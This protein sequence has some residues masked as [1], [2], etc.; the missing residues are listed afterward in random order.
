MKPVKLAALFGDH[1][2]L[3]REMPVPVWG[4]TRPL[5]PV[6]VR[7]GPCEARGLAGEDGK[8]LVRLPPMPAGGPYVLAA[9]AEGGG[10]AESTDVMVGEVWLASGQS[11]ME[12]TMTQTGAPGQR[13]AANAADPLLRMLTV[14]REA[15]LG[16]RADL[17]ASWQC[18]APPA[19]GEFSAVGYYFARRLRAEL[20]VA[21]G[22][23]NASVGGTFIE[24]WISRERLVRNA[25]VAD[26]VAA[27]EAEVNSPAYWAAKK[28][29]RPISDFFPADPGNAAEHA[30]WARPPHDETDWKGVVLPQTWQSFGHNHSGVLWFRKTIDLPASWAG[31]DLSLRIGAVD[32]QDITY[33]NGERVGATG[34]GFK[35]E[36]WNVERDYRVPGRLVAAGKN[37]VAVRAY[38]FAYQG[39]M[40]G[41]A[42]SMCLALADQ[43]E[44]P[45][46][47]AGGWL[48]R[49]EHDLGL[50][51][52][53][54]VPPG[55]GN[56]NS[57][58]I[59][60]DSMIAPLVPAALRGALW[61]QGESNAARASEY[62]R[63]LTDL[64][65]CWRQ[66]FGL[67]DFPFLVVQL[68]NFMPEEDFQPES[69][70]ARLREAQAEVL[71]EPAT[72]L[73]V[74]IDLGEAT[75]IHPRNKQ[76][77]GARLA[78][79]ALAGIYGRPVC[80][81]G[82]LYRSMT[83][84]GDRI[85]LR[86]AH[87]GGGLAARGGPLRTFVIAGGDRGFVPAA[88]VIEGDTVVVSSP[89]VA[90]PLAVRYAWSDNPAGCNLYNAAGLPAP[91]FRTDR[92]A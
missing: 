64:I 76:D 54:A 77:V 58:Y 51:A 35:E 75:D 6:T 73:A 57:P 25:C 4:W 38:S 47:L 29:A 71:S 84:E 63:L 18:C 79:W 30:G 41:P 55:P 12:W 36:F 88:A 72:G 62:R 49:V 16:R 85:R 90:R 7:L 83:I 10:T 82:P 92:W 8:F 60:Y 27:Y 74:A 81:S 28:E 53:P 91:P 31:R 23:I 43:S 26:R 39:G 65:R 42:S 20:G 5:A 56:A 17:P 19:T 33:F 69:A 89:A 52:A 21:V 2:V 3:Q 46:P 78:Q 1:A 66:D 15:R 24:A 11:N 13:E 68:A 87:L 50:V 22:L 70:W 32:K 37:T 48:Y 34:A 45:V 14:P 67:G 9:A 80:P 44:P 40:I 86:F 59:L 61:Y